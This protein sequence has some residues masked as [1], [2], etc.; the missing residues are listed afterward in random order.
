MLVLQNTWNNTLLWIRVV[1]LRIK[2]DW[3]ERWHAKQQTCKLTGL[4]VAVKRY[5]TFISFVPHTYQRNRYINKNT[6][7]DVFLFVV[8]LLIL[9]FE[10]NSTCL[11]DH[12]QMTSERKTHFYTALTRAELGSPAERAALGGKYYPS[13]NAKTKS[14]RNTGRAA[15]ESS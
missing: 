14:R 5:L 6:T 8:M 10:Y 9:W 13:A 11:T 3:K 12:W 1:V 7:L 2:L 4:W 15:I